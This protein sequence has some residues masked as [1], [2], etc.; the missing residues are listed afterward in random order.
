[1]KKRNDLDSF[2]SHLVLLLRLQV[3]QSRVTSRQTQTLVCFVKILP[4]LLD[5]VKLFH[6][7]IAHKAP[8]ILSEFLPASAMLLCRSKREMMILEKLLVVPE[9]VLGTWRA[10]TL[11]NSDV[12]FSQVL[13]FGSQG[14]IPGAR[15][16]EWMPP[17]GS[18]IPNVE[19]MRSS[20]SLLRLK[21]GLV[22][23]M[24]NFKEEL[25]PENPQEGAVPAHPTFSK[26]TILKLNGGKIYSAAQQ[27]QNLPQ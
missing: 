24:Q 1:M 18:R 17:S 27:P 12:L 3:P 2:F 6:L 21:D 5:L 15:K 11:Q 19:L 20:G 16:R 8:E 7:Q 23:H 26:G 25:P 22:L 9:W 14:G 4:L 13:P 10:V